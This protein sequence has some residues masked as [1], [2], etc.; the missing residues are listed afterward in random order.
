MSDALNVNVP[1]SNAVYCDVD[2]VSGQIDPATIMYSWMHVRANGPNCLKDT[3]LCGDTQISGCIDHCQP[4]IDFS[5]NPTIAVLAP[6]TTTGFV[7]NYF[8][9]YESP[10]STNVSGQWIIT[11][12]YRAPFVGIPDI[13]GGVFQLQFSVD[14][15]I[16]RF[17][18]GNT[19]TFAPV[20]QVSSENADAQAQSWTTAGLVNNVAYNDLTGLFD[21]RITVTSNSATP[22]VAPLSLNININVFGSMSWVCVPEPPPP[23]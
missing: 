2:P 1:V 18:Q 5:T 15:Q 4:P 7:E 13:G 12:T 11:M 17:W 20:V 22:L 16:N 3:I 8:T 21:V 23:G 14:P 9:M 19:F 6:V 10:C